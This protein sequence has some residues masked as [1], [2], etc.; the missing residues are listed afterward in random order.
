MRIL[1]LL[2]ADFPPD[3]RV[4]K[5]ALSLINK[6]HHVTVATYT[7]HKN[8]SA[9]KINGI[10]IIRKKISTFTYKSSVGALSYPFY[11]NFWRR[12]VRSLFKTNAFDVVHIHDLP[13]AQIGYEIK[14][15]YNIP[16]VLDLHENYPALLNISTHTQ[17][18][19][20]RFIYSHRYWITYEQKMIRL[21][22]YVICVVDEM[23]NR[24]ANFGIDPEKIFVLE[25]TPNLNTFLI[26][27]VKPD[28]KH[29]TLFYSG[30]ISKHRGIQVIIRG[31]PGIIDQYPG[32][33]FWIVGRGSY[34]SELEKL[35]DENK[36]QD[37]VTFFGWKSQEEM[38]QLLMKSDIALIPHL[39]SDHTDNTFPN[40]LHE[41][42]HANKPV[43]SSDCNPLK[44]MIEEMQNGLIYK[45]DSP[46]DF[47]SK[48][49]S[50]LKSGKKEELGGNGKSW[51][52]TKYNWSLTE[53]TLFRLYDQINIKS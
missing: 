3:V 19:L 50:L 11:F 13:L 43:I 16:F 48:V 10:K 5:E 45:N 15:K 32:I 49:I 6:G 34:Q 7:F 51:V 40:K 31:L 39:K 44:R 41:Y 29:V 30:G 24:L 26:P 21:A 14:R 47:A 46:E 9:D 17:K 8:R 1:M 28:N 37:F 2:E 33:R 38:A 27:D 42:A 20:A 18:I 22:D 53:N 4:E 23:K 12:F 25:N 36:L 35:A 52:L